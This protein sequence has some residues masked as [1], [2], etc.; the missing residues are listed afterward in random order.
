MRR[1]QSRDWEL[2]FRLALVAYP[3]DTFMRAY[4]TARKYFRCSF[5][6]FEVIKGAGA[7]WPAICLPAERWLHSHFTSCMR[8]RCRLGYFYRDNSIDC[9]PTLPAVH[10][11]VSM[12]MCVRECVSVEFTGSFAKNEMWN[13][14]PKSRRNYLSHP[15]GDLVIATDRS[16]RWAPRM[17][18]WLTVHVYIRKLLAILLKNDT[19]DTEE[20]RSSRV[21]NTPSFPSVVNRLRLKIILITFMGGSPCPAATAPHVVARYDIT[22]LLSL[23]SFVTWNS[24]TDDRRGREDAL[25]CG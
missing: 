4:L 24:F 9:S 19:Q 2:S 11:W 18:A 15:R 25:D 12:C 7:F 14:K 8:N 16:P 3:W 23:F 21:K 5:F 6:S 13:L 20:C 22:M 17:S 10:A 1:K